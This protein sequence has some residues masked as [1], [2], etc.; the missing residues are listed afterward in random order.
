MSSTRGH[1]NGASKM[2]P[3]KII[4]M[5]A[6]ALFSSGVF[7]LDMSIVGNVNIEEEK[8][9][10]ARIKADSELLANPEV[11][12]KAL[13]AAVYLG[14]L[15]SIEWLVAN[16]ASPHYTDKNGF[17]LLMA[18]F[19]GGKFLP[20]EYVITK[21]LLDWGVDANA[22]NANRE[23]AA[24]VFFRTRLVSRA[25]LNVC[26]EDDD[27]FPSIPWKNEGK[28]AEFEAATFDLLAAKTTDV[29]LTN[30]INMSPILYITENNRFEFAVPLAKA[31]ANL[32]TPDTAGRTVL[33]YAPAVRV[34]SLVGMGAEANVQ[35]R[36]GNTPLHYAMTG[37]SMRG[38]IE[39]VEYVKAL[40][41]AGATDVPN[42]KGELASA[43][44]DSWLLCKSLRQSPRAA[45]ELEKIRALIRRSRVK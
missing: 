13:F 5:M 35:D 40:L 7:A 39:L 36:N 32:N 15:D 42:A 38:G 43:L 24:L 19:E 21:W 22:L 2:K 27:G 10:I 34:A 41:A 30:T 9:F 12:N 31:G 25:S 1:P 8:A 18:N 17:N 4:T 20:N 23:N 3:K 45:K 29:N 37:G 33:Y 26:K 11:L 14:Y 28:I 16:G 6:M 44:G